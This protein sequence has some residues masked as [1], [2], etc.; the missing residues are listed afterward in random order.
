M[1]PH[2]TDTPDP[3]R[4]SHLWMWLAA[5][6]I[7]YVLSIGPA[8]GVAERQRHPLTVADPFAPMPE[9]YLNIYLPLDELAW[10]AHCHDWLLRYEFWWKDKINP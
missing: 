4:K 10:G 2:L 8:Y 6:P 5:L 1:T 7:L 9:W 3:E